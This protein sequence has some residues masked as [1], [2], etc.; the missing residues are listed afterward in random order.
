MIIEQ[1]K[2]ELKEQRKRLEK[3]SKEEAQA[4]VQ[5][6]FE[7]MHDDLKD[8]LRD[9]RNNQQELHD[10]LIEA[11]EKASLLQ[12]GVQENAEQT[13]EAARMTNRA[14]EALRENKDTLMLGIALILLIGG[15]LG[16]VLM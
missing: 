11:D 4:D 12:S 5:Q 1:K 3:M 6:I 13:V 10:A 16:L 9:I 7:E 2:K 15:T 8:G 14:K